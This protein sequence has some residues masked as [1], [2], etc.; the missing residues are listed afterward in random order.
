MALALSCAAIVTAIPLAVSGNTI[1]SNGAGPTTAAAGISITLGDNNVISAN[2]I[3]SNTGDGIV[4]LSGTSN[5]RFTKNS[6]AGNGNLG[7]DLSANTTATGDDVTKNTSSKTTTSGANGL[8][9]FP[10]ITQAVIT[11]T[12]TGN[13]Q[14]TGYAPA[15][16][17]IEFFLSDKT[18]AGFGQGQTYLFTVLE[19]GTLAAA[20][21]G[22]T[23]SILDGDTKT[24]SY[25]GLVNGLDQG[26]ETVA[27]RF[28]FNIP[29]S[30][31]TAGQRS[32]LISSTAR[33]TA[34]A[35][36]NGSTTSEFSGNI[37]IKQNA[38]LPVQLASFSAKAVGQD[39]QL[40]WRTVQELN[41]D[42]FVIERS[43]DGKTFSSVSQIQ[44]QG[45]T[46]AA[47]DYRFTD[48]QAGIKALG[49]VAYYRLRQVDTDG[50]TSYSTVQALSFV[51]AGASISLYPNP[52]ST[53]ATL[54]LSS[55]PVGS[56][57]VT[58]VDA[59]G[60]VVRQ[61]HYEAGVTSTLSVQELPTGSY[62]VLVRGQGF[63]QS[64]RLMKE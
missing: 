46:T 48:V 25:T 44:G 27:Q 41:N 38:P 47:T 13:L 30:T 63:N 37:L 24:G 16:S 10:V 5:N 62:L 9:N 35:T 29:L 58:M 14:L 50:T 12:S 20:A 43:F 31:L 55:L 40:M 4:A 59:V 26:N 11:N 54:D 49:Q 22:T 2:T 52:A 42:H 61:A 57:Q 23:A 60:R 34:T 39:A 53:S 21:N 19:G 1:S 32:S 7:I 17:T 36:V 45:T 56:Y 3:T 15:G 51:K 8:L 33:L 18:V 6:I 28:L 64:L